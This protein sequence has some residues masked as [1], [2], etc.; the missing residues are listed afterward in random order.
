M[1]IENFGIQD[2]LVKNHVHP[3]S[4][5][6]GIQKISENLAEPEFNKNQSCYPPLCWKSQQSIRGG[7]MYMPTYIYAC[8]E[9]K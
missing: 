2:K 6:P 8:I 5:N 4:S 9:K 1:V 3:S 7:F